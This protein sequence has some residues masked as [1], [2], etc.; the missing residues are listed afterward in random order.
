MRLVRGNCS[1]TSAKHRQRIEFEQRNAETS[2][3]ADLTSR[4]VE[5]D[6]SN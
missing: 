4:T 1:E 2:E 6:I 3:E 5:D